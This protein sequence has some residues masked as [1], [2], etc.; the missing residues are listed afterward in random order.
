MLGPLQVRAGGTWTGVAAPKWRALAAALLA[1]PGEVVSTAR[2]AR[3]TLSFLRHI[4]MY[5]LTIL[6]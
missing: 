1:E 2:L 6:L 4:S 5:G 3:S